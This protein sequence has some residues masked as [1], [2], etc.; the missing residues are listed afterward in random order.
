[1]KSVRRPFSTFVN[2]FIVAGS[3]LFIFATLHPHLIFTDTTPAGG[4]MGAHVWGPAYLRDELLPRFRLSGWTPDWYFG[5]PALVFYF[6]LPYL[7]I[8]ILDVVLPY[9]IA[10][11][12]ISVSGVVM[13]PAA[14][15][16]FARGVG[17]RRCIP[18]LMSVATLPF[19]LDTGFT[20]YGGN[21]ASTLAGEFAFSI[22]LCFAFVFLGVVARGLD[23]GRRQAS[24]AVLLLL[25]LTSH[26]L[27][28]LFAAAGMALLVV[29][30]RIRDRIRW[31]VPA[32][33][34]GSLLAAFWL[35]P[36]MTRL[37]YTND[38]GWTK[39]PEVAD[40]SSGWQTFRAYLDELLPRHYE[41]A[42]WLALLG[43]VIAI[44][45]RERGGLT[46]AGL[47]VA[48]GIAFVIWPQGR[49]WNAR[50]LPFWFLMLLLLAAYALGVIV[51]LA[52]KR[53]ALIGRYLPARREAFEMGSALA[54]ALLL[55]GVQIAV[56]QPAPLRIPLKG[57]EIKIDWW[58]D[59]LNIGDQSFISDWAHWNYSGYERK[60]AY[61]EY[62]EVIQT[63][64]TVGSTYGCGMALWE[65]E[66]EL[67]RMG[68]PMALMLLP[69]WTDGCIGSSEGLYFETTPSVA[70]HFINQTELSARP[71]SSQRDLPYR[72]L[73][74]NAGV[75]HMQLTGT[76][77]Y[78]ALTP[79]IQAQARAHPDLGDPIAITSTTNV[80]YEGVAQ[81][82]HWEVYRV[83]NAPRVE[84]LEF[85]PAV[86]QGADLDRHNWLDVAAGWYMDEARWPVLLADHGPK[87]WP[88]VRAR[89][90]AQSGSGAGFEPVPLLYGERFSLDVPDYNAV[91]PTKVS[92]IHYG[93]DEIS[94]NVDRVG[95]PVLVKASYFPNW[96][97]DGARGPWRVTPN[98]M[99]V[100][101]TSKNV[102][103]EYR[104]TPV[105]WLAWAMT[106]GGAAL[107]IWLARRK[108]PQ[109]KDT[110]PFGAAWSAGSSA[111]S[112]APA[113]MHLR[114]RLV[115]LAGSD[116]FSPSG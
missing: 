52:A 77:Y 22:S 116:D 86:V 81:A 101:P 110:G 32:G 75:R 11:K 50:L 39:L 100:I 109:L 7:L 38:M 98:M 94:F 42:A 64:D 23:T 85:E 4:D 108:R 2:V 97:A 16:Y 24:A 76:Q 78:M 13:L 79:D 58:P 1:M 12:V 95:T 43:L 31:A 106:I 19:L 20:I 26:I 44:V 37:R 63:M 68:T 25:T 5:F 111:S 36:F 80:A 69:Y 55:M 34:A 99:V 87:E 91:P 59:A 72:A 29:G 49:L 71:S 51:S 6:P 9:G 28:T 66:S 33:I 57:S 18:A 89:D 105:D 47:A 40:G 92:K 27:P 30:P 93:T 54:T 73:D 8:V 67:D 41:A 114:S 3:C 115:E 90:N 45:R 10:F 65:Y 46:L 82:R 104:N 62:R 60:D 53:A 103:L 61:R 88:R 107:A 17:L 70:F 83:K 14:V 21:I 35:L 113:P 56:L 74:L 48:F 96:A 102:K 112:V 15:F 84:P